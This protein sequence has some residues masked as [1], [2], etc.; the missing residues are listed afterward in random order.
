MQS[1]LKEALLLAATW[2]DHFN[3]S[4]QYSRSRAVLS[5]YRLGGHRKIAKSLLP[6]GYRQQTFR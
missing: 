1:W 5:M 4:I 2:N 3:S 6:V